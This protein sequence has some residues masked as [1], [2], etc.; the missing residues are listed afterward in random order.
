MRRRTLQPV[1]ENTIAELATLYNGKIKVAHDGRV[2]RRDGKRDCWVLAPQSNTARNGKYKCIALTENGKQR[3]LLVHRLVAQAYILNPDNKR[4]V[5]HK[6]GNGHNNHVD[7]LEWVTR[8]EN[9]RHAHAVGLMAT[10]NTRGVP[11]IYCGELTMNVERI[12]GPCRVVQKLQNKKAERREYRASLVEAAIDSLHIASVPPRDIEMLKMYSLGYTLQE[13]GTEFGICRERARQI[14]D[15]YV[16]AHNK[17]RQREKKITECQAALARFI[18]EKGFMISVIARKIDFDQTSL[19]RMLKP[20]LRM[21]DDIYEAVCAFV[22][23]EYA[24]TPGKKKIL[25]PP[26][27]Q[28]A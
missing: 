7:N 14:I 9:C 2:Y 28:Q 13:I 12:C 6:D 4:E 1:H 20:T 21:P 11:C 16:V 15:K 24:E 5:N 23:F 10:L 18:K 25:N 3:N 22:G 26:R 27:R 17:E 8:M 19:R